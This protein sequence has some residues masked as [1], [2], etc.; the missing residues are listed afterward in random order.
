M[1]GALFLPAICFAANIST[2]SRTVGCAASKAM[3]M[4]CASSAARCVS[5]RASHSAIGSRPARRSAFHWPAIARAWASDRRPL[6]SQLDIL[7]PAAPSL[8]SM[9]IVNLRRAPSNKYSITQVRVPCARMRRNSPSPS[10]SMRSRPLR[11]GLALKHSTAESLPIARLPGSN[12]G[13]DFGWDFGW[14]FTGLGGTSQDGRS[15][16]SFD[17]LLM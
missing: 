16:G 4:R 6:S 7:S 11:S 14:E 13:W 8:S 17:N 10:P 2:A 3:A 15:L 1:A 12:S 9:P 5:R